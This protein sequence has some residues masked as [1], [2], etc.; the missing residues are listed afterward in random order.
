MEVLVVIGGIFVIVVG[1]FFI[2]VLAKFIWN[3]A[4]AFFLS[5]ISVWIMVQ[6]GYLLAIIGL[7]LLIATM[8]LT[9]TWQ[10]AALHDRVEHRIEK[11]FYLDD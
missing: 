5:P 10:D 7:V 11:L 3:W 2:G 4:P 8:L 6:G 9:N 1:Y